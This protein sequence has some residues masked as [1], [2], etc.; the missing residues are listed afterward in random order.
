VS[1][2]YIAALV[3][4]GWYLMI[5]PPMASDRSMVDLNAP[6]FKWRVFGPYA[7]ALQCAQGQVEYAKF[8]AKGDRIQ[9]R[10]FIAAQCIATDD[11]RLKE[12]P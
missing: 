10:Q 11:P 2:R 6:L 9:H 12:K 3:S 1:F 4:S 7:T 5:P 8:T